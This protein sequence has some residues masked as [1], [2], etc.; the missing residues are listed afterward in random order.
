M[1]KIKIKKQGTLTCAHSGA[2]ETEGPMV[3]LVSRVAKSM[4][5]RFT[6]TVSSIKVESY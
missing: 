1:N 5:S 4:D 3:L 2:K 6:E